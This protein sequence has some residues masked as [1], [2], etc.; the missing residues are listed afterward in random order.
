MGVK[1]DKPAAAGDEGG[2]GFRKMRRDCMDER[3]VLGSGARDL[4]GGD[5]EDEQGHTLG[6]RGFR[7]KGTR[8]ARVSY[9]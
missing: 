9:T 8:K 6:W 1:E 4:F 3:A 2:A 5:G 7:L